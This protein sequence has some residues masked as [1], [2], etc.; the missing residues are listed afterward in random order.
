M[1]AGGIALFLSVL[2]LLAWQVRS[3]R[4]PALGAARQQPAL[5][6]QAP[7]RV[8]VRR[9]VRRVIDEK[10]IERDDAGEAV[11]V[12][13]PASSP[14]VSAAPPV[15]YAAPAPAPAPAP[16]APIVTKTS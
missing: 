13:A 2:V 16:S 6:A 1:I 7:Q 4:D 8:L 15:V 9:V 12:A 10:V 5:V 11:T 14:A 3:G